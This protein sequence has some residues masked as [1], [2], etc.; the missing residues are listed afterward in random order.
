LETGEVKKL[1]GKTVEPQWRNGGDQ[2]S[3]VLKALALG[4]FKH[5][6]KN[7]NELL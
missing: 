4:N 6:L 2:G 7:K 3:F 5:S 1:I